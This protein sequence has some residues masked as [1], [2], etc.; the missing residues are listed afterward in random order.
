MSRLAA[1][2]GFF[3]CGFLITSAVRSTITEISN[4]KCALA[5]GKWGFT[6]R[7]DERR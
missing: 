7:R 2:F 4:E 1:V 5:R 6:H 3:G